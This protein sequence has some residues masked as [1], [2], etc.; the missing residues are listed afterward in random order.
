MRLNLRTALHRAIASKEIVTHENIT[1]ETG[2]NLIQRI[3][4][5]IRP[6]I[7]LGEDS[8][9]FLV[10]FHDVGVAFSPE[11]VAA[12]DTISKADDPAVKQLENELRTTKEHLQTTIEELETSNEELKSSNEELLSMN[13]EL[14]SSN[15]ELQSSKEEMQSINE[16][17][18][19]VNAELR[20]K[21]EEIDQANSD[22]QN[23]FQSTNVATIILDHDL[24]IK[25]FTPATTEIFNLIESDSGRPI[26]DIM[27]HLKN[28]NLRADVE[29][30]LKNSKLSSAKLC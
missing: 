21:L 6:M 2:D 13:E 23:F 3:N 5:K 9:F 14:Q 4:L 20:K 26:T 19:T 28:V 15:E 12:T 24:R 29:E 11:E 1:V 25:K 17:I 10:I 7:E 16:E 30:S 27:P 18:E 8:S 22:L